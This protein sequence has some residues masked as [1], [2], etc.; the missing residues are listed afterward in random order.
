MADTTEEII[1]FYRERMIARPDVYAM[2][3][4]S[5]I[6]KAMGSKKDRGYFT[7]DE[8]ITDAL[9]EMHVK[10]DVTIG[11][12]N[13]S[14]DSDVKWICFDFDPIKDKPEASLEAANSVFQYLQKTMY[15][16]A[17]M[18]E[19][20]G[21][22][23]HI[24]VFFS[25]PVDAGIA[26]EAGKKVIQDSGLDVAVE[27]FPKQARIGKRG[28]GNLVKL[29]WGINRKNDKPSEM[30]FP[31]SIS[32]IEPVDVQGEL[33]K[34]ASSF[35]EMLKPA[36]TIWETPKFLNYPCWKD[37]ATAKLGKGNRNEI[38]FRVACLLKQLGLPRLMVFGAVWAWNQENE[39]PMEHEEVLSFVN[40]AFG[41]P[42]A[43]GCNTIRGNPLVEKYCKAVECPLGIRF[44]AKKDTRL[45]RETDQDLITWYKNFPQGGAE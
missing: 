19:F 6:A 23:Y 25:E 5:I 31:R 37:I 34:T 40:S 17:A 7:V 36:D 24:W 14:R 28:Y 20:S 33:W 16:K 43:V 26:R 22:G 10:G 35:Y 45:P 42:N 38:G 4:P 27:V 11:V 9:L 41:G 1:R 32:L 21:R 15:A 29:P 30:Y 3:L 8:K 18:L 12:Y 2:Q 39:E 13:L 44:L